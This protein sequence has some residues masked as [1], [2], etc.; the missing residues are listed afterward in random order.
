MAV[1][2]QFE[3]PLDLHCSQT[4]LN[5]FR[6]THWFE[7][8]LDLHCSQTDNLE[9]RQISEFEYPL[10]LHCSQTLNKINKLYVMFEYPLDLHCSQTN[11]ASHPEFPGLNTLWIYTALK[12]KETQVL[13]L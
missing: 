1:P 9:I 8:P 6:N 5:L 11:L 2:L 7:Y 13:L 4:L 3:Y 12:R 10:D